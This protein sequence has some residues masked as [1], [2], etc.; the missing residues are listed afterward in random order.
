MSNT[1]MAIMKDTSVCVACYACR[2]ACQNHN[3]LP[4]D[5]TYLS[6]VFKE[7]GSFP[8]V[9]YHLARKSCIHCVNPTCAPACPIGILH[10]NE[11]G[12]VNFVEGTNEPCI[13][14]GLCVLACPIEG[15]LEMRDDKVYKCTGCEALVADGQEPACVNTC[16]AD[17]LCY[18]SEEEMVEK[19]RERLLQV[20][21]KNTDAY[22]FGANSERTAA[23]VISVLRSKPSDFELIK[24]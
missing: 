22:L 24:F 21:E 11:H 3:G 23:R 1:Q 10:Q 18:G 20:E 14:C 8:N 15:A 12:F 17:A 4:E 7:K 5:Q 2:V 13:G 16:I 19:A 9:E 6:L